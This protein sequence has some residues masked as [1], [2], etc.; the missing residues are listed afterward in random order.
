MGHTDSGVSHVCSHPRLGHGLDGLATRY[1][2]ERTRGSRSAKYPLPSRENACMGYFFYNQSSP[3]FVLLGSHNVL[4]PLMCCTMTFVD[5][6]ACDLRRGQEWDMRTRR[7]RHGSHSR[8][9]HGLEGLAAGY[10]ARRTRWSRQARHPL[11]SHEAA[12]VGYFCCGFSSPH[13]FQDTVVAN[14]DV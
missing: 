4:A 6:N 5:S 12:R 11:S 9:G 7:S 14:V 3:H 1:P 10:P 13:S 2:V 8:H